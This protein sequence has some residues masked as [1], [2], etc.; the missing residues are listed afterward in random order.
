MRTQRIAD[1]RA[2]PGYDTANEGSKTELM[3]TN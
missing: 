2:I 1:A 3:Q